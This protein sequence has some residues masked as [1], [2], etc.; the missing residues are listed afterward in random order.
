MPFVCHYT[1]TYCYKFGRVT[2]CISELG[3]VYLIGIIPGKMRQPDGPGK[4]A[5]VKFWEGLMAG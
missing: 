4:C 1:S 3:L 5:M 2:R